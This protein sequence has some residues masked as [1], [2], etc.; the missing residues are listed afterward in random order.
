M[1]RGHLLRRRQ[2]PRSR[3]RHR[4]G[5]LS[6]TRPAPNIRPWC[7]IDSSLA[8]K[9]ITVA[10]ELG[11]NFRSVKPLSGKPQNTHFRSTPQS[12]VAEN[13]CRGRAKSSTTSTGHNHDP[14]LG[15]CRS[16]RKSSAEAYAHRAN[17]TPCRTRHSRAE[18]RAGC[19]SGTS[20]FP[21]AKPHEAAFAKSQIIL[22]PHRLR[23]KPR[24]EFTSFSPIS[25][26]LARPGLRALMV[27]TNG[28]A[29]VTSRKVFPRKTSL[30]HKQIQ[31]AATD[32]SWPPPP[33]H[34]QHSLRRPF[35]PSPLRRRN[36]SSPRTP[37]TTSTIQKNTFEPAP[38]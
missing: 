20:R 1:S 28:G 7:G 16:A 34:R 3:S 13:R 17:P 14:R 4:S 12:E 33:C 6:P 35:R 23:Q 5:S 11:A 9:E 10:E 29:G 15:R 25:P 24:P 19:H 38:R 2:I 21:S 32:A 18:L 8:P 26:Q 37:G 31:S 27:G 30:T 22:D 36:A